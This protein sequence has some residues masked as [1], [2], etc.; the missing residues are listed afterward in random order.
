MAVVV[1]V[2]ICVRSI[3]LSPVAVALDVGLTDVVFRS[4][5]ELVPLTAYDRFREVELRTDS[6]LLD[7]RRSPSEGVLDEEEEAIV[8]AEVEKGESRFFDV[9]AARRV[10]PLVIASGRPVLEKEPQ[11]L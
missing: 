4:G 6:L 11:Q 5:G 7:T 2:V 8:E 9:A 3:L 10:V 1:F